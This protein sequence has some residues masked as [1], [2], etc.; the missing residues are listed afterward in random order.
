MLAQCP[1][2]RVGV[3]QLQQ[4]SEECDDIDPEKTGEQTIYSSE[5]IETFLEMDKIKRTYIGSSSD[6]DLR[7][8]LRPSAPTMYALG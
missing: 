8:T 1:C 7:N 2:P 3:R 6:A 5:K 4:E